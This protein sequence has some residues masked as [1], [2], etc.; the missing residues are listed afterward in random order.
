MI[1][2]VLAVALAAAILSLSLGAIDD[3]RVANADA[4]I[5]AGADRLV[6]A[7]EALAATDQPV[8]PG[9]PGARRVLE[10]SLPARTWSAAGVDAVEVGALPGRPAGRGGVAWTV[11]GGPRRVLRVEGVALRGST[12][13]GTLV[14]RRSGTH[15]LVLALV[16]RDGRR[17]VVV[18]RLGF[19]RDGAASTG[20]AWA[21]GPPP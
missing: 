14:L 17:V 8:P 21:A 20:H 9:R 10:L 13:D 19:I 15:R 6:A 3:A 7:A 2:A 1:R 5:E 12:P 4:R 11:P 18:S 16:E